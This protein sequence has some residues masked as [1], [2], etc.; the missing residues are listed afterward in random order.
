MEGL[1][2]EW[3]GPKCFEGEVKNW[4]SKQSDLTPQRK[5]VLVTKRGLRRD[6]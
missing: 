1:G 6:P 4:R 5:K 3:G 2:S